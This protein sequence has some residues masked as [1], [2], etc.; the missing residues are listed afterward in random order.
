MKNL[1]EF[2]LQNFPSAQYASGKNEILMK[3]PFCGDSKDPKTKHFYV[4][5]VEGKPHFYNCFKCGEKG[6]LN[7]KVL[8]KLSIYDIETLN[9]LDKYNSNISKNQAKQGNIYNANTVY[10][11]TNYIQDSPLTQAKIKYI[12]Y[13]LLIKQKQKEKLLTTLIIGLTMN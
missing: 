4:S 3:C 13:L 11:I 1:A 12:N 8:R 6:I 7:S 9:E 5:I 2:L 10:R